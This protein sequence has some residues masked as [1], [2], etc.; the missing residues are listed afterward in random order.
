MGSGKQGV[1][2]FEAVLEHSGNAL[3]WII[4]RVP[5]DVGKTWGSRGHLKVKGEIAAAGTKDAG[6]TFRTVVFPTG[7]G[8]HF[9]IVNKKMQRGAHV[10]PG[11]KARFRLEPDM[12]VRVIE[13]PEEWT[14][15]LR[16]SKRLAKFHHS[17]TPSV[18]R[19]IARWI[20]DPKS[21]AARERRAE[22]MAE[23]LLETMEAERELPPMIALALARNP[24]ARA[25]WEQMTPAHRRRHLL[26]I[27]YYRDPESRARR[28]AKAM[29]EMVEYGKD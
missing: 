6:F 8:W 23:R 28:V 20:G 11:T 10:V 16:Q 19:E 1:K 24:R 12:E 25:G 14:R 13:E 3:N 18:R 27:F 29:E 26:G 17:L 4:A 15:V 22:Q 21:A 2:T 7:R 9:L 5:F